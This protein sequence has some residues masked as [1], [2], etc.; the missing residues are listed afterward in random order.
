MAKYE[1]ITIAELIK[2]IESQKAVLPAMQRNFVWPEEKICKLFDS[3]MR[4]YPIGTFLF[5]DVD[6]QTFDEYVFNT[7]L[8][9]YI[10]QKG[11]LQRGQKATVRLSEYFAVLDGQQRITSLYLGIKGSYKIHKKNK[12]WDDPS[13]FESKYLC[14][15]ILHTPED[16][17]DSFQFAF[18]KEEEIYKYFIDEQGN[19]QIWIRVSEVFDP[20]FQSAEY[21]D[22]IDEDMFGGEWRLERVAPRK[23]LSTLHNRLFEKEN[24]NYYLAKE[25]SL[26]QVV[27]IFVR[28]N[29]GGEKLNASDLM[30]S[31]ATGEQGD[32][33]IHLKMKEAIDYISNE[34]SD[35]GFVADKELILT[36]GLMFTECASLSLQK[37]ENYERRTITRI[38]E[39]WDKIVEALAVAAKYI[40]YIG[41]VGTKLTS[42]NLILPIAYYFYKNNLGENH[43]LSTSLRARQDRVFIRQWL[44]RAM[45]NSVFSDGTGSTLIAIRKI[46]KDNVGKCFPL[47]QLM[48]EKIKK[49]LT[50]DEDTIDEI[51]EKWKYS[52]G[53]IAPLLAE[54]AKDYTGRIFDV[55]HIQP[56]AVLGKVSALK[57]L[58]PDSTEE[59]REEY[60]RKCHSLANLQLLEPYANKQKH[61]K[62]FHD[63]VVIYPD[64]DRYYDDNLIPKDVEL[65]A[66]DRFLDFIS[67]REELLKDEI[68][69]A[70][71]S[72]FEEIVRRNHLQ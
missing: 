5:W 39:E 11:R 21:I 8:K 58:L 49:P 25:K 27:D 42:K 64:G 14:V 30:L 38:L 53:R 37:R 55:D 20:E 3:V 26:S 17:D 54:L 56:K 23:L 50:I 22:Q 47:Q 4:D 44:L 69:V 15:N 9:D 60:K 28:V 36:A 48:A 24:V 70:F 63:W 62:L 46:I 43:Q 41:F 7:F 66:F 72:S 52:D 45:I 61:D 6:S 68:G 31:V 67:K 65:Y 57:R 19:K 16:E 2:S 32:T 71:P 13:S 51:L 1:S 34:T 40:E 59:M 35:N 10:E 33:D 29:S 12:R 18:K